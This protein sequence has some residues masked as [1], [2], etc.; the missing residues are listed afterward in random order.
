MDIALS[1]MDIGI[2]KAYGNVFYYRKDTFFPPLKILW[3]I[4]C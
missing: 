1:I 3:E 4:R 2:M